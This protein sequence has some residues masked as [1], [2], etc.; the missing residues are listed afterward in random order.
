MHPIIQIFK[1]FKLFKSTVAHNC[2]I[3]TK[4]SQQITNRS[5]QIQI[6]HSKFKSLTSNSNRSQQIQ[7]AHSKFKLFTAN[8][9]RSQQ[10]QIA[11]N[12][13]QIINS[14]RRLDGYLQPA[15]QL[16]W[17]YLSYMKP[18]LSSHVWTYTTPAVRW[19]IVLCI[20]FPQ[21]R[22]DP[23]LIR[24]LKILRRSVVC[25]H[26]KDRFFV[27][28]CTFVHFHVQEC[29]FFFWNFSH[30]LDSLLILQAICRPRVSWFLSTLASWFTFSSEF[31]LLFLATDSALLCY[32]LFI[33]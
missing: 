7:I 17:K 21:R 8:W 4:C 1:Y 25:L 2:H 10:T 14:A 12:K 11:H 16:V 6:A 20:F 3:K 30:K 31:K 15:V 24:V 29:K 28:S 18:V 32:N 13:L 27:E 26:V 22:F 19:W 5:H 33:R 23:R 9:S